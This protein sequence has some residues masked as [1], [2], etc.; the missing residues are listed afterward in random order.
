MAGGAAWA[1]GCKSD[2]SLTADEGEGGTQDGPSG[3]DGGQIP[4]LD[5]TGDLDGGDIWEH[6]Q[7]TGLYADFQ[8]KTVSPDVKPYKP[9]YELWSDGAEKSRWVSLPAGTKIDISNFDEWNFP[10]GTRIW[11]EF[12]LNGKRIETRLFR[13][14]APDS[15]AAVNNRWAHTTYRWSDDESDAV[16]KDEG[17]KIP[18]IGPDGGIYEIPSSG[19]CSE[20]HNGRQDKILG[21]EGVNLGLPGATGETLAALAAEGSLSA[22][23]PKTALA[24]P[25]R[26][27]AGTVALDSDAMGWLH[28]NCGHCH[29][30][31][32]NALAMDRAHF[33]IKG[34]QLAPPDGGAGATMQ[35][36]DVWTSGYCHPA[37]RTE[38]DAGGAPFFYIRGGL[39]ERS[40][41]AVLS[42]YRVPPPDDP[43]VS[44]MPP[45]D[46]RA[47]DV[48]DH[49]QL[50]QWI[51]S[52]P[53][54]P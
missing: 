20:C 48:K 5:C 37:G 14:L 43:D 26:G 28:A 39:P 51:T 18:G 17:E 36:L 45:L 13:K 1:A 27:D 49:D 10:A 11:K 30:N 47:V 21:F 53:A 33:L 46:T 50:V 9:A 4:P 54:C 3:D 16:R 6:L 52:L 29:N 25:T 32:T 35:Q 42:G 15:D 8:S 22:A 12:K 31:N 2:G 23:P 24:I 38:P 19:M 34:S 41:M 44:Q 7:C 40:E